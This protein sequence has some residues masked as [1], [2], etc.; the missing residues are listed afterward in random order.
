VHARSIQ[1][2]WATQYALKL[3]IPE[4]GSCVRMGSR[5]V[6][7]VNTLTP[8]TQFGDGDAALV[9]SPT[10]KFAIRRAGCT[11]NA[12]CPGNHEQCIAVESTNGDL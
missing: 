6:S 7:G 2:S 9:D 3:M 11:E 1:H 12:D 8:R 4:T 10:R 5:S